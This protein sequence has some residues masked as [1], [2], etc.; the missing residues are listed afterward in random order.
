MKV[1]PGR[2]ARVAALVAVALSMLA[3]GVIALDD[4][5]LDSHP[6]V[7]RFSIS[8]DAGGA[9]WSFQPS[10][11]LVVT[12]PGEI[13]SEGTWAAGPDADGFDATLDVAVTGQ[14]LAILGE[15]S[16]DGRQVALH[17]AATTAAR[18]DDA[19]PWPAV[20]RLIGERL[21]MVADGTP[22]PSPS[23]HDCDRPDWV[24]GEVDWDRCDDGPTEPASDGQVSLT[25]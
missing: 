20:S 24:D 3:A 11:A 7:G 23:P 4:A 2:S 10:G 18:P 25:E 14:D 13:S 8:S 19:I 15:V 9:V 16:P 5:P 6:V 22:A 21:G 17:V 1:I 12:G